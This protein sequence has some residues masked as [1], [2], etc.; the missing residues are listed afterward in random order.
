MKNGMW[1]KCPDSYRE[2]SKEQMLV[3]IKNIIFA[4]ITENRKPQTENLL[5]EVNPLHPLRYAG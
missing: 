1:Y 4:P 3:Y 2:M 5:F